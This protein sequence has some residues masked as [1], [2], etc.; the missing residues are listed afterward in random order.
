[1]KKCRG[2]SSDS[3]S[4]VARWCELEPDPSHDVINTASIEFKVGECSNTFISYRNSVTR[5]CN[6]IFTT[7]IRRTGNIL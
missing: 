3:E 4:Y 6:S 2:G 7:V 5:N 1:M